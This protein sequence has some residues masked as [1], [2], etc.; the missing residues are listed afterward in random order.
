[1]GSADMIV[2]IALGLIAVAGIIAAAFFARRRFNTV[3]QSPSAGSTRDEGFFEEDSQP[4]ERPG[5]AAERI[6]P[7]TALTVLAVLF[8]LATVG[9]RFW[10]MPVSVPRDVLQAAHDS[11]PGSLH[12]LSVQESASPLHWRV[13]IHGQMDHEG[14][15]PR[16]YVFTYTVSR[17]SGV[18]DS[19][20]SRADSGSDILLGAVVLIS[21][22][23]LGYMA[24]I[25][26][27]RVLG[28]PCPE[29]RSRPF[30]LQSE[31]ELTS[32]SHGEY[33]ISEG[34]YRCGT[35]GFNKIE[36]YQ[37]PR[38]HYRAGMIQRPPGYFHTDS[39]Q[40]QQ[41]QDYDEAE[42]DSTLEQLRQQRECQW[43]ESNEST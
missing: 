24:Y 11:R 14:D 22:C 28:S 29:C 4:V 35:C 31:T 20:L 30:R 34:H 7:R 40:H 2:N 27:P 9:V 43:F 17:L 32:D 16:P 13:Q 21:A 12:P 25:T 19:S 37:G 1:M 15:S 42:L 6:H 5:S 23:V 33:T 41:H 39:G 3:Q 26:I 36:V 10:Y 8:L 18:S 38:L